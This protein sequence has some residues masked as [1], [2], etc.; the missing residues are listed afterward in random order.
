MDIL[1]ISLPKRTDRQ[2]VLASAMAIN[3]INYQLFQAKD[4]SEFNQK[5]NCSRTVALYPIWWS[6]VHA[7]EHLLSGNDEWVMVIEDDADFHHATVFDCS[8][9]DRLRI[10]LPSLVHEIDLFQIGF[11]QDSISGWKGWVHK[12]VSKIC[13]ISPEN[14]RSAKDLIKV[15][16]FFNYFRMS[17]KLSPKKS[18]E[19]LIQGHSMRGT[20]AYVINRR[21]AKCLVSYF[22]ENLGKSNLLPLDNFLYKFTNSSTSDFK[23]VRFSNSL[24]N[25]ND[26][27]S[28]NLI[29]DHRPF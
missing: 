26:S 10:T 19:F 17:K 18:F 29:Q 20:H 25:Q 7:M 14:F 8:Y 13:R 5:Y 23:A 4:L 15:W 1:V 22:E 2:E 6:H 21:F 11:N 28:D 12:S 9:I 16:G 27:P 24:I 3:G